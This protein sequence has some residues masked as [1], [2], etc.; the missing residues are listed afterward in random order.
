[1]AGAVS[2]YQKHVFFC[3]NQREP[4]ET[5]C[6][7]HHSRDMR[8][9]A[10]DKIRALNLNGKGKIRVNSA[11]CMDRC[12]EGPVLVVYPDGVWYTYMDKHDI[13]E[14]IEEH[15]LHGRIVTRLK[16]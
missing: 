11:G 13:D 6:N 7:N 16:I 1:L 12:D 4:G 5:C 15:L 3:C 2:H 14:I 9:Y 10:K 8:G